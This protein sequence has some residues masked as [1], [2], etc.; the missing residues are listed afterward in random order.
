MSDKPKPEGYTTGR[1]TKYTPELAEEI[2]SA[3]SSSDIGLGK[4]CDLNPHWPAKK[5]IREWTIRYPQFRVQYINAK[6]AQVDWLVE[7][8]MEVATNGAEDT[9][10]DDDGN[11]KCDTEWVSRCRLHVDTVKWLSSK[12]APKIYGD[13]QK[14]E[15]LETKNAELREEIRQ[16]KEKLDEQNKKEY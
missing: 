13:A 6:A 5:N 16:Y 12:L 4:L 14:V 9:I 11:P 8:A 2:C 7:R 3:I 10:Y 1:P 15:D